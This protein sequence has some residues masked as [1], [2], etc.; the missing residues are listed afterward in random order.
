[1]STGFIVANSLSQRK[2]MRMKN[3]ETQFEQNYEAFTVAL[4]NSIAENCLTEIKAILDDPYAKLPTTGV[5]YTKNVPLDI[6]KSFNAKRFKELSKDVASCSPFSEWSERFSVSNENEVIND[7]VSINIVSGLIK[8]KRTSDHE[9]DREYFQELMAIVGKAAAEKLKNRFAEFTAQQGNSSL[10]FKVKWCR[11]TDKMLSNSSDFRDNYLYID[12]WINDPK[13]N[14][15]SNLNH[16]AEGSVI[17]E[18]RVQ[19]QGNK[20][21]RKLVQNVF[22]AFVIITI[23]SVC[24]MQVF[25]RNER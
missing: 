16:L 20:F 1:M 15:R 8:R 17:A 2:E 19:S 23:A 14:V 6:C 5:M 12:A 24:L 22:I 10:V 25:N 3:W 11:K 21:K 7:I 4:V 13:K 18:K 9:I